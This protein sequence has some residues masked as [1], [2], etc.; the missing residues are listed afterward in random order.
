MFSRRAVILA[1]W[2]LSAPLLLARKP[3]LLELRERSEKYWDLLKNQRKSEAARFVEASSVKNFSERKEPALLGVR[4]K[5]FRFTDDPRQVHVVVTLERSFP[6]FPQSVH[7]DV[8]E[9]WIFDGKSW[10]VQVKP[11][12]K[13]NPMSLHAQPPLTPEQQRRASLEE[14]RQE[15]DQILRFENPGLDFGTL[16]FEQTGKVMLRYSYRGQEP[17]PVTFDKPYWLIHKDMFLKPA[18][19]GEYELNVLSGEMPEGP[20][21]LEFKLYATFQG[22]RVPYSLKLRGKVYM[23]FALQPRPIQFQPGR[24][25]EAFTIRN[26]SQEPVHIRALYSPDSNIQLE[27]TT[28]KPDII[29]PGETAQGKVKIL[30]PVNVAVETLVVSLSW[31]VEGLNAINI[32]V[33]FKPPEAPKPPEKRY[34]SLEELLK[35]V[36][37]N[38]PN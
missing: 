5:E 28:E 16:R 34:Y 15:L 8:A 29:F 12:S 14:A 36:K 22:Q 13:V 9:R 4:V 26:N 20:V 2:L 24:S 18:E 17:L 19:A 27:L 35:M 1:L 38:S 6:N 31:T 23:P 21:D 3:D 32:P 25:E 11:P 33:R 37:P 10:F 7:V 30:G